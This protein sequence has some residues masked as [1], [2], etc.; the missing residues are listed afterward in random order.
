M[1]AMEMSPAFFRG[2]FMCWA[3]P[4]D[5]HIH[6]HMQIHTREPHADRYGISCERSKHIRMMRGQREEGE[7]SVVYAETY[8][9]DENVLFEGEII[10]AFCYL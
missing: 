7:R 8:N 4:T 1:L 5:L 6:I 2:L 3:L 9:E 10:F